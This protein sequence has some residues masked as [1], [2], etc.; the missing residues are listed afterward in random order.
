MTALFSVAHR[1]PRMKDVFDEY[2]ALWIANGGNT[3][4]QF[5]D[6][7]GGSKGLWGALEYVTEDPAAA[8]KYQGLRDVIAKHPANTP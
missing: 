7:G 1:N 4:N 5:N 6:V 3:M 8:P 2:Y